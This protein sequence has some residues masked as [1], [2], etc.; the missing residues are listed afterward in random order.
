ME[1]GDLLNNTYRLIKPI[2]NGG[3]GTI[4]L[5]Y[6]ENLQKY[7]VV[8]KIR[9]RMINLVN[10][11]IE[12]DILK[13]LHH[14]Y[15]PQVYDFVQVDGG[16]F[17]V[18]DYIPGHDLQYYLDQ[19][20]QF[21]EERLCFWLEQLGEVL[22]YLHTRTPPIIHCD[23]KPANI[24][25]TESGDICLIDFNISLDGEN[26]KELVGVSSSYASPEQIRKAGLMIQGLNA[27]RVVV[28]KS[29]DLYSL[30]AVFYR[31]MSG[32]SPV[33]RREQQWL[34]KSME[35][36]YSSSLVNIVD[37][38]MMDDPRRRFR[39]AG[40]L[41]EALSDRKRWTREW[42]HLTWLGGLADGG[43]FVISLICICLMIAG[44]HQMKNE[45][46]FDAYESYMAEAS[47]LYVP[48]ADTKAF[49]T[50]I[51]SGSQL[52]NESD[53]QKK[54]LQ[55]PEEKAN[56]LYA[57]AL[58]EMSCSD[59]SQARAYL[60]EAQKYDRN[61][62]DIYRDLA[63]ACAQCGELASAGDYM[64][65]AAALGLP[66][67]EKNLI[68][69]Q[70]AYMS[71]D[72]QEAYDL[73]REAAASSFDDGELERR[74]A[75][76]ALKAAKALGNYADCLEFIEERLENT[77]GSEYALWLQKGGEL[78]VMAVEAADN[79]DAVGNK[80][81]LDMARQGIA[82]YTSLRQK[83]YEGLTDL[84]NLAY[85]YEK[86]GDL[87]ACR[88]LLLEL[89]RL[90][91]EEYRSFTELAY[92]YYRMEND[93]PAAQR[94]YGQ[95]LSNYEKACELCASQGMDTGNDA[96]LLKLKSVIDELKE[97]GWL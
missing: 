14:R 47:V 63:I 6:H 73:A 17:T 61:N 96:G 38:C 36:P 72:W 16:I 95:V 52:L 59:Y 69:A 40:K 64:D 84:Y 67:G 24:M 75:V 88:D 1:N 39:S 74:G 45:A 15:L 48:L 54:F 49:E 35:L 23:I 79:G 83:G 80:N 58:G 43:M 41:R 51:A 8:K 77:R 9:T 2:G 57:M 44:W 27:S 62:P 28:D 10:C 34:L 32:L 29:S 87:A 25:V 42:R 37:K 97:K 5:A 46:F 53:Y 66:A 93:K 76:L 60:L 20:W 65:Q 68:L 90:Y 92:I 26:N 13:S 91:P 22:E 78:C 85:L 18:M 94:D 71:S 30:G 21:G 56:V 82:F 55:Y 81:D 33:C 70:M 3:L 89:T 19:G 31:L 4:Y 12:V 50:V 7:V 11:R 86:S